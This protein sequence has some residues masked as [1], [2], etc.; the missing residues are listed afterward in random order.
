MLFIKYETH[1]GEKRH[2]HLWNGCN[3]KCTVKLYKNNNLVDEIIC[4][5]VGCKYGEFDK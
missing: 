3:G 4:E 5:N 2:D 1:N